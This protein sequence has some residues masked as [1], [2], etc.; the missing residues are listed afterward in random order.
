M[1]VY[2]EGSGILKKKAF[3]KVT[4]SSGSSKRDYCCCSC[5]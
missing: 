5:F 3:V 1:Y 4:S 2:I